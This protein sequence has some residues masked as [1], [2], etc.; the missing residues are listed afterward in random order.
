MSYMRVLILLIGTIF[1]ANAYGDP[2][3]A[4]CVELENAPNY[5]QYKGTLER[6]YVN[7]QN[8]VIVYLKTSFTQADV[9]K[10]DP[11]I[12]NLQ[13]ISYVT[14]ENPEF[15]EMFFAIALAAKAQNATVIIQSREKSSGYL[16]ADR[17]WIL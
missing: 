17:I 10:V 4:V 7:Y 16:K 12:A 5:C 2:P 6:V 11:A 9:D 15:A 14:P 13:A 1:M 8:R 3:V